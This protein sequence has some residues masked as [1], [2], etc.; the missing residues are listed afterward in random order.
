M[1]SVWD[2]LFILLAV[3]VALPLLVVVAVTRLVWMILDR[4][5]LTPPDQRM[6]I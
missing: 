1:R 6:K 4:V 2:A 3:T 5:T